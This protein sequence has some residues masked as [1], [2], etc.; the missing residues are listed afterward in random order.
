MNKTQT[1]RPKVNL[2]VRNLTIFGMVSMA[3][4][5][6]YQVYGSVSQGSFGMVPLVYLI[7]LILMFFTAL[8]Y[9]QF[10]KEFPYSGSVYSYIGK[11]V[12]THVGFIAGWTILS[13]YILAPALMSVFA[14]LW[15]TGLVPGVHPMIWTFSFIII[16]CLINIRGLELSMK[17]NVALF[18]IQIVS[19]L[20]FIGFA[21]NFIFINGNGLGGF[22][23]DPLFQVE[24]VD[25]KFISTSASIILLGFIGFDFI[26]TLAGETENPRKDIGKAMVLSLTCIG[27]IF[28]FFSYITALAHPNY[29][30]L[31]SDMALF[32]ITKEI[33][34]SG[35]YAIML[36]IN[37]LAVGLAVSLNIQAAVSRLIHAMGKDRI[38]PG[39]FY[40]TKIHPKYNTPYIA[41]IA[42]TFISLLVGSFVDLNVILVLITFGAL[43]SFMALNLAV[44]YYFFFKRKKRDIKGLFFYLLFPLLGFAVCAMV[45]ISFDKLTYILGFIWMLVGVLI[46]AIKSK[47][48]KLDGPIIENL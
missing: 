35:F 5:A 15:M 24:H 20:V 4:L 31:D 28:L 14:G 48:Y 36:V 12:N 32:D 41:V 33:G 43:T 11:G 23:L 2:S 25:W 13:D 26:S 18:W 9:A 19:I 46:G 22:S 16:N 37:V 47:G 34:G 27:L 44:I 38:L 30:N 21:I 7:G 39:S 29:S 6:P 45:W 1:E 17:V 42:T 8:S 3:P 40:L 10:S